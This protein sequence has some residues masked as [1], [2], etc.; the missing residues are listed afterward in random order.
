MAPTRVTR[1][2]MVNVYLVEEDDGLTLIDTALPRS[3]KAIQAAASEIGKPIRR[4]VLTHAHQDH[5][6]SL[7]ELAAALPGVEVLIS[8]RDARLLAKDKTLDPGEEKGKL[9]GGYP[10][11]KTKPTGTLTPGERVGSLEVVANPGHTPGHVA[12]LDT[13]DRTVFCGDTFSTLGGTATTAKPYWRFPLPGMASWHGPTVVESARALRA[14]EPARLAPGHGAIVE[15]PG[16]A[17]DVAIA[18]AG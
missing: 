17:M 14:L 11:T 15:N 6:G 12:L 10:G 8:A 13:R 3:A 7:D 16:A 9:R 18:K 1:L 5:V 2:G 4:I